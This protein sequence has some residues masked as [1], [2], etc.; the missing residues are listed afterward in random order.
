MNTLRRH[1]LVRLNHQGWQHALAQ[2]PDSEARACMAHWAGHGLPVVVARQRVATTGECAVGLPAPANWGRRRLAF[3]VAL[4]GVAYFDAFPAARQVAGLLPKRVRAAWLGLCTEL[5]QAGVQSRVYGSHGWQYL[6]GLDH[7]RPGS[8]VDLLLAVDG[9]AQ[10]D[11]AVAL[12]L[13]H[14]LVYPRPKLDG[15][16]VFGNGAAV[17]WRE[18]MAWRSGTVNAVLVKRLHSAELARGAFWEPV[19]A[20]VPEVQP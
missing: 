16:L 6:T 4:S 5:G 13:A 8:D 12:L 2:A 10:A 9:P 11:H 20:P 14:A 15:E 7:L 3:Q 19:R 17:A 18:W 1:Q